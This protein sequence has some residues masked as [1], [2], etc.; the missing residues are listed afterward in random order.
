M[1]GGEYSKVIF[2]L[3]QGRYRGKC[4]STSSRWYGSAFSL[5]FARSG[6]GP[7]VFLLQGLKGLDLGFRVFRV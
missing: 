2:Y 3:L 6:L 1:A 5:A 7:M 4:Q